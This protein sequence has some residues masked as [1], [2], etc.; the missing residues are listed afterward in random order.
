MK[1]VKL[2]SSLSGLQHRE[3]GAWGRGVVVKRDEPKAGERI[4]N[5]LEGLFVS[6]SLCIR[7]V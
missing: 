7:V 5:Y 6:S 1:V 2:L 3:V 4:Q